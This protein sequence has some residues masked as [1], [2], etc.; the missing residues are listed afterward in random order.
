MQDSAQPHIH[1]AFNKIQPY[2]NYQLRYLIDILFN[3]SIEY[4]RTYLRPTGCVFMHRYY[5]YVLSILFQL[6][7]LFIFCLTV[8]YAAKFE[9]SNYK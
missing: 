7:Y 4:I 5:I 1:A 6:Q 3:T 8:L 2:T 9:V